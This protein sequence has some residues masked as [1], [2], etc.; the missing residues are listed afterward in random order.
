MIN[1]LMSNLYIMLSTCVTNS[2]SREQ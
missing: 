1:M 2:S